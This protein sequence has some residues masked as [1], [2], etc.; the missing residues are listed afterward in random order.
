M[1]TLAQYRQA[2][3]EAQLN[4]RYAQERLFEMAKAGRMSEPLFRQRQRY[5]TRC[6]EEWCALSDALRADMAQHAGAVG[7]TRK[8]DQMPAQRIC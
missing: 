1:V 2:S 4:V 3:L 6:I 8:N 5:L 7:Y